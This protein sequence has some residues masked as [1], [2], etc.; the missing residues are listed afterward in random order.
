[1]YVT[2]SHNR[3]LT[4]VTPP[5]SEPLTLSIT[6][7]YLR[8]DHDDED[9]FIGDLMVSA[10]ML[11]ENWLRRSLITQ[12]WKLGYDEC[13]PQHISLPMGPVNSVFNVMLINRD[14]SSQLISAENYS[15]N[16]AKNILTF[17]T[18]VRGFHIEINYSTGYGSTASDIP[19]PLRQGMLCHVASLYEN[20]GDAGDNGLPEQSVSLYLPFREVLL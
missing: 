8:I 1:M 10:R 20:R 2:K 17:D 14:N 5:A 6:K 13:A 19:A 12:S 15:L 9:Q 18:Q 3:L 11:A 7:S 4:R 16:A